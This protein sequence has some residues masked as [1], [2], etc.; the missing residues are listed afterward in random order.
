LCQIDRAFSEKVET[1]LHTKMQPHI[2]AIIMPADIAN[3]G[4]HDERLICLARAEQ[5]RTVTAAL[6]NRCASQA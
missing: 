2:A 6:V 4:D 3:A 5:N 1:G